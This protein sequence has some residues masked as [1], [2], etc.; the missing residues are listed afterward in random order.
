M[1]KKDLDF[2][3]C[4]GIQKIIGYL[5]EERYGK[6]TFEEEDELNDAARIILSTGEAFSRLVDKERHETP[7]ND[8]T[9]TSLL[10]LTFLEYF[11]VRLGST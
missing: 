9:E 8:R 11:E 10:F 2:D 7:P 4:A 5:A 1:C 3:G 6:Y